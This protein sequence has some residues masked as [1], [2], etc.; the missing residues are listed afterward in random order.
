MKTYTTAIFSFLA[1]SLFGLYAV[2]PT[3]RTILFLRREIRDK[4]SV[5]KQMEDK[6]AALI[7]SQAAFEA[8]SG[9]LPLLFHAIP[10]TPQPVELFR[11][12]RNL[13]E[14][15]NASMSSV[16]V[17]SVPLRTEK[18]TSFPITLVVTGSYSS[19]KSFLDGALTIRRIISLNAI[20]F[21]PATGGVPLQLVLQLEAYYGQ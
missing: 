19:L 11:S 10:Q 18:H 8:T 20:R 14:A 1:V 21:S 15:S 4:T 12:L 5:N 17:S 7:E 6:I 16:S 2:L 9:R 3:M 13:A